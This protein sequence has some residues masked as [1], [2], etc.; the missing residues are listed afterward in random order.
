MYFL[1]KFLPLFVLPAG[2]F[3]VLGIAGWIEWRKQYHKRIPRLWI[4]AVL[5][6][7]LFSTP[8]VAGQLI[9]WWEIP[10][11]EP[12][13]LEKHTEAQPVSY[14]VVLGGMME[15]TGY[16]L[17]PYQVLDAADR[18]LVGIRL[19]EQGYADTLLISG[20]QS[21]FAHQSTPSEAELVY[22]WIQTFS[23]FDT[24]RVLIEGQSVNTYGNAQQVHQMLR[25]QT[26]SSRVYLITSAYHM[27]RALF[28]FRNAGLNPLP[29]A[30][31]HRSA[32]DLE[33]S[34]VMNWIPNAA[35]LHYSSEILREILGY[36]YYKMIL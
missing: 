33:E 5:Q 15:Y 12:E 2:L 8:W 23:D 4:L 29:V 7:Y 32:K 31:D 18:F 1:S 20:G 21:P 28:M 24:S 3:F 30:T 9:Q 17:E 26:G 6:F 19:V 27:R 25:K 16:E 35:A 13:M 14:A 22:D 10:P 36:G 34:G 11:P